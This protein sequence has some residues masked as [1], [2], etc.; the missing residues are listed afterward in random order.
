MKTL[1]SNPKDLL[2]VKKVSMSKIPPIAI[3]HEALAMMD[4]AGKYGSFNWRGNGVQAMIYIDALLR[5]VMLWVEGQEQAE[6][7][8]CHHLGHARACLGILLDAQAT[9]NLVDDRPTGASEKL[10][11]AFDQIAA[12]I[13]AM[14]KR[15]AEFK[16]KQTQFN[17]NV[18]ENDPF[19][20]EGN[21][22]N[23]R[24]SQCGEG[25]KTSSRT[26]NDKMLDVF[27]ATPGPG[28]SI[29]A[30]NQHRAGW[31]AND[32]KGDEY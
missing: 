1:G 30:A 20:D 26:S 14:N 7:S 10:E 18:I 19:H 16:A 2:G 24:L 12:K 29:A 25:C 11:E 27:Q 28:H 4:G 8:G 13:P 6:D 5:H 22:T 31:V 15:H 17:P 21:A 23:H 9:G 3:A 32:A